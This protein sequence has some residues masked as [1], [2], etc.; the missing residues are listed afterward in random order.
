[1]ITAHVMAPPVGGAR[2]DQWILDLL[3]PTSGRTC[4]M[5]HSEAK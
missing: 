2:R 3:V 1:M 5:F 4:S